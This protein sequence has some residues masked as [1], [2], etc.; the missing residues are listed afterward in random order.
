MLWKLVIA[1]GAYCH[2]APPG[3]R[4]LLVCGLDVALAK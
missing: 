3:R 2:W 1:A 4:N